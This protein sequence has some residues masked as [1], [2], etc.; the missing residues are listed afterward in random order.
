MVG[1]HQVDVNVDVDNDPPRTRA[2]WVRPILY[3]NLHV[4]A[5]AVD[6]LCCSMRRD[7]AYNLVIG[8]AV[9]CWSWMWACQG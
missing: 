6:C 7:T 9:R 2:M 5:S 1:H 8:F 4:P 3:S